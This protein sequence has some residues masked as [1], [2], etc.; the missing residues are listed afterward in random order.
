[1]AA[2][3]TSISFAVR[4]SEV[5]K[6]LPQ[7]RRRITP[8]VGRALETLDH[9]IEYLADEYAVRRGWKADSN[10]YTCTVHLLIA[11]RTQVYMDAPEDHSIGAR[12]G[13]FLARLLD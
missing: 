11:L 2:T 8:E 12:C 13:S 5:A 9:A 7:Q 3:T 10:D 6:A 4:N 1:M